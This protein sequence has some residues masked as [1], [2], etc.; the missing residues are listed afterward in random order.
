MRGVAIVLL[1]ATVAL[2]GC[3]GSSNDS[4]TEKQVTLPAY[5]GYRATTETVTAGSP[6]MCRRDAQALTR[7]AV[8]F[9]VPSPTPGDGY[10]IAARTQFI[11]FRAHTCDLS[12]LRSALSRRLSSAERRSLVARWP[13]LPESLG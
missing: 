4:R 8:A 3:G 10:F 13:F 12:I 6:A 7:D 11:D 2:G 5:G 1:L 9:L